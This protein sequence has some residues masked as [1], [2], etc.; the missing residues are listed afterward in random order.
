MKAAIA[1]SLGVKALTGFI[2]LGALFTAGAASARAQQFAAGVQFAAP[3]FGFA[4]AS[5]APA[6]VAPVPVR[7]FGYVAVDPYRDAR[8][9]FE[10]REAIERREHVEHERIERDRDRRFERRDWR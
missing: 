9:R 2:A 5:V 6:Y 3:G 10:E 8:L 4:A 1:K 7:G